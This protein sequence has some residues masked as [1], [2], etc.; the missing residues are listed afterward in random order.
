M[1]DM[2]IILTYILVV[3]I[4]TSCGSSDECGSV[5]TDGYVELAVS[6]NVPEAAKIGLKNY[7]ESSISKVDVF[8][9]AADSSYV[10]RFQIGNLAESS[11]GVSFNLRLPLTDEKRVLHI[12][13]NGRDQSGADII[14]F[15]D[16]V[17]GLK[18]S[19]LI[20]LLRTQQLTA[21]TQPELPHAM[22][23]RVELSSV[24]SSTTIPAIDMLRTTAAVTVELPQA[25]TDNGLDPFS[26]TA[27]SVLNTAS[28]GKVAP[29]DFKS[30]AATPASVSLPSSFSYI[31]YVS[32]SGTG[33]WSYASGTVIPDLY[34]YERGNVLD[35]T[36][37]GVVIRGSYR[38]SD[39]Y[40]KVWLK[41][42]SGSLLDVVRNHR[43]V[44]QISKVY[45]V[46]YQ[47]LQEAI[48]ASYSSNISVDI[49][50]N[51]DDI[52]DIIVDSSH[53]LGISSNSFTFYGGGVRSIGTALKT[54][55]AATLSLSSSV[56]WIS[57][58]SYTQSGTRYYMT[59][60]LE[61]TSVERTGLITVRAGN[62]QRTILIAQK[63][64]VE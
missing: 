37:F 48:D 7:V 18:E 43:Y 9:F 42:Q 62:L 46:G 47:T 24:T 10:Q 64:K 28:R 45:G 32:S 39:G 33:L 13:A 5:E 52:T 58:L 59:A 63:P 11:S 50:D 15:S 20:P 36:G 19:Q 61:D 3:M 34:V 57:N 55:S 4:A 49:S 23:G 27:F 38:G 29:L 30:P 26:L 16:M 2:K 12:V 54:N 60:L 31:D 35:K 21:N 51:N 53:Q 1:I 25:T 41:N 14:N 6:L 17:M 44:I 22:W 56:S 40:Y 8:M